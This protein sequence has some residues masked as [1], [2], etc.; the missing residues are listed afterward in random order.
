MSVLEK[1]IYIA[2]CAEP[3][4]DNEYSIKLREFMHGGLDKAFEYALR[5]IKL[6]YTTDLK[7]EIHPRSR[8]ALKKPE[9]ENEQST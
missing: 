7:N 3:N 4:R 5:D 6:R 2:D 9:E 8:E 1:I